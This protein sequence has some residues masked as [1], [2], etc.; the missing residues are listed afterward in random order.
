MAWLHIHYNSE[1]LKM[2]VAMEVLLPQYNAGG[3]GKLQYPGPYKTLYLLHDIGNDHTCWMRRTS[4][5]RYVEGLPIAVVMPAG[6]L[7][8]YTDME[9]GRD[10][11]KFITEE[12]P[13]ICERMFSLSESREDRYIAGASVGGYGAIKAGLLVPE[14]FS[15]AAAFS[16]A[17]DVYKVF[18]SMNKK[19]AEDVFGE[20]D[21]IKNSS[22]DLFEAAE[23]F[24]KSKKYKS[25]FYMW[26][27]LEDFQYEANIKFKEYALSLGLP[28]TYEEA[29]GEYNWKHWDSCLEDFIKKICLNT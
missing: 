12:L 25:K 5:E 28:L 4:I 15:V 2:P 23:K 29:P 9:Y 8:Y 3:I 7:G 1:I 16:G 14:K 10:Y 24:L 20:K 19:L 21:K 11:F 22:N 6:H 13:T 27:G 18:E 17:M 26:C